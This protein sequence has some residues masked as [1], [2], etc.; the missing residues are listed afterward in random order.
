MALSDGDKAEYKEMARVIVKEV[1]AEHI[2]NCP[3]HLA[4][5]ISRARLVGLTVGI[6]VASGV[7]SGTAVAIIMKVFK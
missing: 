2:A 4:Y 3:H 5:L 6:I 7:S 1:L